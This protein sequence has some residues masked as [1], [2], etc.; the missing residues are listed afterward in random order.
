MKKKIR[1]GKRRGQSIK[2]WLSDAATMMNLENLLQYH[3]D[4]ERV[5]HPWGICVRSK[6]SPPK[7]L[8]NEII[9]GL[10]ERYE[11]WNQL[12]RQLGEPYYLKVWIYDRL[13]FE[14]QIVMGIRERIQWYENVFEPTERKLVFPLQQFSGNSTK[15]PTFEWISVF[16]CG[17]PEYPTRDLVWLGQKQSG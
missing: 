2:E 12:L 14:S 3:Y 4:Y 7:R 8:R 1:C 15:Y 6:I 17:A 13:F 10:L 5:V 9:A 16:D 11:Q